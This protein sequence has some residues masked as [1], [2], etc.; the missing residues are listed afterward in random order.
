M[1]ET[2]HIIFLNS[3]FGKAPFPASLRSYF[4]LSRST[5]VPVLLRWNV[6]VCGFA[7]PYGSPKVVDWASIVWELVWVSFNPIKLDTVALEVIFIQFFLQLEWRKYYLLI[8]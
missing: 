8:Y 3:L 4:F 7:N 2:K 6:D 1:S 5:N